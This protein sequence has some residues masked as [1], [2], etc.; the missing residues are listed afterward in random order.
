[1]TWSGSVDQLGTLA[2]PSLTKAAAAFLAIRTAIE[3]GRLGPG[4]RLRIDQLARDLQM[5]ST[6]IR[7]ALRLLQAEGLLDYE[8][9]RGLTVRT[10]AADAVEEIYRLRAALEPMATRLAVE[11]AS[12]DE[13]AAI[14]RIHRQL[15]ALADQEVSGPRGS[16]LNTE[17]HRCL[18][19]ASHS[20]TLIDFIARLWSRIPV[21]VLWT[22]EH[23][24]SSVQ[25]HD[26][27][28]QRLDQRDAL[29]AGRLM[30]EH[31]IGSQTRNLQ[32]IARPP[33]RDPGVSNGE[34]EVRP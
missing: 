28:M 30:A 4:D 24:K 34:T 29:G 5:S 27:I 14:T 7:E 9:H 17:W 10:F 31:I 23:M 26:S 25:N 21:E 22:A 32:R 12:E 16:Q 20:A 18:Y 3:Q 11:R 8:E 15:V 13:V 19:A 1:M 33:T 6:P 2:A